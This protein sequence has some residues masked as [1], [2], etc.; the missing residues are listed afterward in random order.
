MTADTAG[1]INTLRNC[2]LRECDDA[3]EVLRL[4]GLCPEQCRTDGGFL[5]VPR[6]RT[7]LRD[8]VEDTADRLEMIA[9]S[10]WASAPDCR[11]ILEAA[12]LLRGLSGK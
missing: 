2:L 3:D 10:V 11:L 5:N 12:K 1:E 6:I 7:M 9:H 8:R 4:L